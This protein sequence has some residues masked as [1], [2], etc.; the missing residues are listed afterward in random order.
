LI[1]QI[2]PIECAIENMENINNTLRD[3][4][5]DYQNDHNIALNQLTMKIQGVVDAAVNGG[6]TKYEEAFLVEDY[7]KLNPSDQVLVEKLKNLIADQIPILEVALLVHRAKVPSD[8]LPLHERLEECFLKMQAHVESCYGKRTTDLKFIGND[9]SVIL[10]KS[11][12][13]TPQLTMTTDNRL[14]ETSMGSS[15]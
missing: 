3:L 5:K 11:I 2:A 1:L 10:R 7:L 4:L 8:L 6:T 9:P 12:L 13:S 14:S 15:E